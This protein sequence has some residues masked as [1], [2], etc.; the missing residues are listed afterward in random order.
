MERDATVDSADG[1]R[2]HRRRHLRRWSRI[3][4]GVVLALTV[5]G[6]T[7]VFAARHWLTEDLVVATPPPARP[8]LTA[9]ERAYYGFVG[10]RLHALVA[11]TEQLTA[12]GA[13]KSRNVFALEK[14]YNQT[15]TLIDEIDGYETVHGVPPKFAPAHASYSEGAA[16]VQQTMRDAESAF[17]HGQWDRLQPLL[18]TFGKATATLVRAMNLLDAAG[19]GLPATPAE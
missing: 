12:L 14:G 13:Q 15:N 2:H 17:Y 1:A 10:P 19:G 4:A 11:Q 6:V 3:A 9:D 5:L 8:E 7:G 16:Q 18:A